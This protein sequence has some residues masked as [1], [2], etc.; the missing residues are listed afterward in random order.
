MR[1][2][3][4]VLGILGAIGL[5]TA[6]LAGCHRALLFHCTR[7]VEC[8]DGANDGVCQASGY[9]S[10]PDPACGSGQR[11]VEEAGMGLARSCVP[12]N[13]P[14][15]CTVDL[16]SPTMGEVVGSTVAVSAAVD[17]GGRTIVAMKAYLNGDPTPVCGSSGGSLACA[18]RVPAG[19]DNVEVN[20]WESNGAVH[21]SSTVS[22]ISSAT[23]TAGVIISAP[24]NGA[25]VI[26]PLMVS[27]QAITCDAKPITGMRAYLNGNPASVCAASSGALSCM[28]DVPT[29]SSRID[30]NAW[31]STGAIYKNRVSFTR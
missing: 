26:T 24:A 27:A 5:G 18:I 8:T 25:S 21:T 4:R 12:A 29:G 1:E 28:V 14:A 31:D 6:M 3:A 10:F 16:T 13:I 17:C 15:I 9:C 2:M 11:Y 22:F 19:S 23:C 20:A 30:V 7:D